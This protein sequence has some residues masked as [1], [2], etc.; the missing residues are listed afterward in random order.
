MLGLVRRIYRWPGDPILELKSFN[1]AQ[2]IANLKL[3]IPVTLSYHIL[4][5]IQVECLRFLAAERFM[6]QDPTLCA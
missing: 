4:R 3:Y 1:T 2:Y 5:H 6:A